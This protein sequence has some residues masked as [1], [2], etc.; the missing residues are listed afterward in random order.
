MIIE[1]KFVISAPVQQV[2]DYFLDIPGLSGCVPG[3]ERVEQVDDRSFTGSLVVKVGPIKTNFSG[4]AT[5]TELEPPHRLT[6]RAQGK[7]KN[8]ASMVSATFTATLTDL[9]LDQ[10]EVAYKVDVVIRGRLAR[11]GQGV[12]RETSKQITQVFVACA[13]AKIL[14]QIEATEQPGVEPEPDTNGVDASTASSTPPQV[15]SAT[16]PSLLSIF[17]KSIITSISNWFKALWPG[18]SKPID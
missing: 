2:W 4:K 11:F 7:D 17:F 1:D 13:Q 16:P 5:L 3:A 8:T 10:T 14:A 9:E 15:Q 12:I 6:A 18:S